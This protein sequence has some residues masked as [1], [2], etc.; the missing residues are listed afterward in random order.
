MAFFTLNRIA[1]AR[2]GL[3]I[4][5][6]NS[7]ITGSSNTVHNLQRAYLVLFAATIV[8]RTVG[9]TH[10]AIFFVEFQTLSHIAVI[11]TLSNSCKIKGR[12]ITPESRFGH[13]RAVIMITYM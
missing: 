7:R 8:D 1:I 3:N 12:V 6:M 5:T 11:G 13:D 9:D 2:V 4:S 10:W